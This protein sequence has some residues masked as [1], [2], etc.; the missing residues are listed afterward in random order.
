MHALPGGIVWTIHQGPKQRSVLQN[1]GGNQQGSHVYKS[2]IINKCH[3]A[4][5]VQRSYQTQKYEIDH[6][7]EGIINQDVST[8]SQLYNWSRCLVV[9]GYDGRLAE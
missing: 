7:L 4:L 1:L 2:M 3:A 9:E 8:I 5:I 6:C